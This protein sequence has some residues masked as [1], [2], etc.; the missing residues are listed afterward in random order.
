MDSCRPRKL[1]PGLAK[2][3]SNPR[4][5]RTSTM[6]SEPGCSAVRTSTLGTGSFSAVA[7]AALA[8]PVAPACWADTAGGEATR[9]AAPH[10]VP[11][12]KLRRPTEVFFEMA[13]GPLPGCWEALYL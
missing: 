4:V 5:R 3:Y 8:E 7:T 10:A 9:A 2:M 6:K 13:M 11:F 1:D 12:R